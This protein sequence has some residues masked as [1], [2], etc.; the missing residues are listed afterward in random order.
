MENRI[1]EHPFFEVFIEAFQAFC[2]KKIEKEEYGRFKQTFCGKFPD[3][4]LEKYWE[5]VEIGIPRPSEL[6]PQESL[7]MWQRDVVMLLVNFFK[8]VEEFKLYSDYSDIERKF[9]KDIPEVLGKTEGL[10]FN[11]EAVYWTFNIKWNEYIDENWSKY[12]CTL[13]CPLD[14]IFS[15]FDSILRECFFPT[16]GPYD[17]GPVARRKEQEKL[18][19]NCAPELKDALLK[20]IWG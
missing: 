7:E 15:R 18:L 12:N 8:R 2:S 19:E 4:Y 1:I 11:L 20:D 9:N 6:V 17:L 5:G 14:E 16:P 13:I 10:H 3:T